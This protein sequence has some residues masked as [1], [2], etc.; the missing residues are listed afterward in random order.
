MAN[1]H[2]EEV[3]GKAYDSELMR[4]LVGYAKPYFLYLLLGL[5]MLL[6]ITGTSLVRPYLLKVA[7]DDNIIGTGSAVYEFPGKYAIP[8]YVNDD[9]VLELEGKVYVRSALLRKADKV[10]A[11]NLPRVT[12]MNVQKTPVVIE[13]AVLTHD[14]ALLTGPSGDTSVTDTKGNEYAATVMDKS[15]MQKYKEYDNKRIRDIAIL[16]LLTGLVGFLLSYYEIMLLNWV[17]QNIV[18]NMRRQIFS[19]IMSHDMSYLDKNP[20]GRLVTR[21]TNDTDTLIEMYTSVL[22]NLFKDIFMVVGIIIVMLKLD[23]RLALVSYM[24]LPFIFVATMLFRKYAM[25]AYRKIRVALARINATLAENISGMKIIHLFSVEGRMHEDFDKIN[26]VYYKSGLR[27]TMVYAIFRPTM[28]LIFSLSLTLMIWYGSK[29]VMSGVVQIGV[30]YAFINY[31]RQFFNPINEMAEKYNILQA[32]MASSERIFQLLDRKPEIK[33]DTECTHVE[34][35]IGKIEFKNVWFAY[36]DEEWV[37]R[38]VS[39][40]IEP[41]QMVAFVGATGAGKTSIINLMSRY[42]DIQKGSI[43]IDGID[44]RKIPLEE[45]RRNISTVFQDVFLFTG[46]IKT[47]IRLNNDNISDEDVRRVSRYVNADSFISNLQGGYDAKVTERGSTLSAGQ[48]QLLAFARA[49]AFDPSV[50]VLDEATA[51]IDTETEALIQDALPKLMKGRTTIVIAHRLSTIQHANRII[52]LHKGKIRE[53]GTHQEL[54]AQKGIYHGLYQLQYKE[55]FF[56]GGS[57]SEA[58]HEGSFAAI[59]EKS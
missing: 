6:G 33:N 41:G 25:D 14:L 52:V 58:S 44:I 16:I 2:E 38:D 45:L 36:V 8:D 43:L 18:Y 19:H 59:D 4:R 20:V 12:V 24:L 21:V 56:E 50:L 34:K 9:Y 39:F 42:Y 27:E 30:F 35:I 46:D 26:S 11:E 49:L 51:N 22:V 53:S 23:Y 48:R 32:A 5:V 54:L 57:K 7:I 17:G 3:L 15:V 1:Y 37:L 55:S 13:G 10:Q 29:G 28:E 47:N 40:T 31:V